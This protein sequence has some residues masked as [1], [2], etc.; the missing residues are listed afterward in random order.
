MYSGKV[1]S[2]NRPV[3]SSPTIDPDLGSNTFEID[4]KSRDE[5]ILHSW[6]ADQ[7]IVPYNILGFLGRRHF[8]LAEHNIENDLYPSVIVSI[9]EYQ[10]QMFV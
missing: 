8:E 3:Y 10:E 5:A 1:T 7:R 4:R 9:A 2:T 6:V